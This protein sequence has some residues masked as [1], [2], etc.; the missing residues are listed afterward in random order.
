MGR[1]E[2]PRLEQPQSGPGR[3]RPQGEKKWVAKIEP[4]LDT[5]LVVPLPNGF[6]QF[7]HS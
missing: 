7:G 5:A 3:G 6:Q 2:C 4:S 1:G